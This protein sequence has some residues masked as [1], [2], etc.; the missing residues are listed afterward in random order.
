V[1][2][3][4]LEPFQNVVA[5]GVAQLTTQRIWPNT[6][7]YIALVL[8]GTTF[9]KAMITSLQIRLGQKPIWNWGFG[10]T[11]A[12]TD[13][14]AV[15]SYEGRGTIA[16]LLT[17]PFADPFARTPK[18]Q[19]LGACD[20]GAVG[21]N[22]LTLLVTVTGATAPTLT[23]YAEVA[24]P[25]TLDSASNLL[26]RAILETPLAVAAAGT[27]VPFL[28]NYGQAGGALLRRLVFGAA[29]TQVLAAEIKRDGL[30]IFEQIP[31]AVFQGMQTEIF[32]HVPQAGYVMVD[33]IDDYIESKALTTVRQDSQGNI[34]LIPQQILISNNAAAN[35]NVYADVFANLNGL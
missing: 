27:F 26:F 28:I 34:S 22:N 1:A 25:K 15:N 17:L 16:T 2:K 7:E 21:V 29:N 6:L 19:Y 31:V 30:D 32:P 5:S 4:L 9:T 23:G 18:T 8:G 14:Q 24:P 35:Y 13:I 33:F 11:N 12:G 10:N 20:M 3:I